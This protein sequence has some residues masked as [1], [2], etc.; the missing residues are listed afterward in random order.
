M[1]KTKSKSKRTRYKLE[2]Y[3]PDYMYKNTLFVRNAT[4]YDSLRRNNLAIDRIIA[5]SSLPNHYYGTIRH[6][7]LAY[8]KNIK[9]NMVM[10]FYKYFSYLIDIQKNTKMRYYSNNCAYKK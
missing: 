4:S 7:T 5:S 2:F 8:F 6:L 1:D 3:M 10:Y 9:P